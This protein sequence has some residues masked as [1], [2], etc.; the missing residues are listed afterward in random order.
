MSE[1]PEIDYQVVAKNLATANADLTYQLAQ[2]DNLITTL[3][4]QRDTYKEQLNSA[5]NTAPESGD[6]DGV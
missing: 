4:S 1:Y 3:K 2:Y 6:S 5:L